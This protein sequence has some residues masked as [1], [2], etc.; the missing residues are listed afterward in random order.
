DEAVKISGADP[1]YHRR[2]LFESINNGDY[3]EW[4]FGV[5]LFTEEEANEFPFDH[6]DATKLIPE[7]LVPVKV[8]GKMVLNR[9]P[10]NFF[11][12]TE[13]VA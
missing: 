5:Q 3:P 9:Y 13:Q 1:D 12:E 6:L 2:D 10:D 11:A 8:V 4:E 7:E